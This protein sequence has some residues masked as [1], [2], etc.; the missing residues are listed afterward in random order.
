MQGK[1]R[2]ENGNAK[3]MAHEVRCPHCNSVLVVKVRSQP[4]PAMERMRQM[5]ERRKKPKNGDESQQ[6]KG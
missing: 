4:V 1:A 6:F 3:E 5:R 2:R